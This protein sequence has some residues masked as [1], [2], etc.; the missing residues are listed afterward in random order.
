MQSFIDSSVCFPQELLVSLGCGHTFHDPCVGQ[1]AAAKGCGVWCVTCPICKYTP[2]GADQPEVEPLIPGEVIDVE[3]FVVQGYLFDAAA[4]AAAPSSSGAS[5]SGLAAPAVAPA[6]EE[7]EADQES[8]AAPEAKGKG[9][10]KGKGKAKA[11]AAAAPAGEGEADDDDAAMEDFLNEALADP[12]LAKAKGKAKAKAK[13]VPN[14]KSVP[15]A[16][17]KAKGKAK[18]AAAPAAAAEEE[19]EAAEAPPAAGTTT[20]VVVEPPVMDELAAVWSDK[21]FCQSCRQFCSFFR[22]RVLSKLTGTW[23]CHS[24]NTTVTQMRRL[25]GSWP[26]GSFSVLSEDSQPP[27]SKQHVA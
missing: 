4:P 27:Q 2:P 18:A 3:P 10:G 26:S 25:H 16:K 9:K 23:R 1:Y 20:P 13:S 6:E 11:N 15:K 12:A 8:E 19:S 14:A 17:G 22:C 5:S 21:V 7:S 24:C